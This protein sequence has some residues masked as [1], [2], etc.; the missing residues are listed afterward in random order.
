[1]RINRRHI[2]KSTIAASVTTITGTPLLADTHYTIDA[3]DRPHPIASNGNTWELVSDTVMGGISNG[4]IERNHF[5]KRNALR[6]QG[7]VSLENN[8]GF[9]QIALD[10]G[11]NQRPMDASQWTGIELDV[12]GNTEVYNIHLRTND[13]KRPW[14]SYRQS[15]LAKTEWTTVRLPFDSFTNHRVDK[16]INLTGLR[17]IGIVAIGRAFHVDIAI[18]G[19]RLYP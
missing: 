7:D 17:R 4:T 2:L 18:S 5:K 1:M 15:F 16:P 8:G 14:Q 12:A 19:I 9:I 13:I 11:P 10:L 3:L 6:M